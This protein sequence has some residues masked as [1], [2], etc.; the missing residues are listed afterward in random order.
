M[1]H[2]LKRCLQEITKKREYQIIEKLS[3]H[4]YNFQNESELLHFVKTRCVI[5]KHYNKLRILKVDGIDICEWFETS[6]VSYNENSITET[7]GETP[8]E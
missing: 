7:I 3:E 1:M 5:Q 4:G 8:F 2:I 6:S